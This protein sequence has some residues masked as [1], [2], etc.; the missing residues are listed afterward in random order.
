M[1]TAKDIAEKYVYGNHDALTDSQE[2]TDM[3]K[4]IEG[5]AKSQTPISD[6]WISVE[7]DKPQEDFHVLCRTDQNGVV[8]NYVLAISFHT[9][10]WYDYEG[11]PF[12]GEVTHYQELP[13]PPQTK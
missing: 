2:I 4:D 9:N 8:R 11:Q 13:T 3:V 7:T 1:K 5:F 6:Q 10:Q 12:N